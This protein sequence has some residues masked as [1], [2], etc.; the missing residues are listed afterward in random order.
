[1]SKK[2]TLSDDQIVDLG[3]KIFEIIKGYIDSEDGWHFSEETHG[4]KMYK[5]VLCWQGTLFVLHVYFTPGLV[6]LYRS[7]VLAVYMSGIR[8]C[9]SCFG[10]AE[11]RF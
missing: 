10:S 1:M 3:K 4:V 8:E 11:S 6:E 5:Y 2:T 7:L 9:P